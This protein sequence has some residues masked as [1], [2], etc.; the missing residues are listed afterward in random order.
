MPSLQ[1]KYETSMNNSGRC[2]GGQILLL[3]EGNII[4]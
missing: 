1:Q 4:E 3:K 2:F